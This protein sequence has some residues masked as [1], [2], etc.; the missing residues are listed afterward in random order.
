MQENRQ[1]VHEIMCGCDLNNMKDKKQ[2]VIPIADD[3]VIA[4]PR[5]NMH[6]HESARTAKDP[7]SFFVYFFHNIRTGD[8]EHYLAPCSW[9]SFCICRKSPCGSNCPYP[10]YRDFFAMMQAGGEWELFVYEASKKWTDQH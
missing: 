5:L 9:R 7:M 8:V 3:W 2:D 1:E 10:A 6:I 4:D